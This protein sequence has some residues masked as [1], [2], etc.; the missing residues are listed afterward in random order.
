MPTCGA[1]ASATPRGSERERMSES[2]FKVFTG[3]S[4]RAL[5]PPPADANYQK[6]L[7]AQ[8]VGAASFLAELRRDAD[9]VSV[10]QGTRTKAGGL[11]QRSSYLVSTTTLLLPVYFIVAD[12]SPQTHTLDVVH[13]N[14]NRRIARY[15]SK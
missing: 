9:V 4:L 5:G 10:L 1:S 13:R 15:H 12:R 8:P 7:D 11:F 14:E 3:E 6:H 2:A